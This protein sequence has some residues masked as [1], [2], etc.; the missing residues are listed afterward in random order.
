VGRAI[1]AAAGYGDAFVHR[2]G[3]GIG[4][5]THEDPYIVEG[6]ALTLEPGMVFSI[7]PGIYLEGRHGARIED[8]VV[9]TADGVERLNQTSRDLAEV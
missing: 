9:C 2:T 4:V 3:H 5:E 6:N 8:I 7:E 1:I